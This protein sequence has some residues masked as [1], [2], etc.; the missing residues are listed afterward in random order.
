MIREGARNAAVK[1]LSFGDKFGVQHCS[2]FG[3]GEHL[4]HADVRAGLPV[5]RCRNAPAVDGVGVAAQHLAFMHDEEAGS[6]RDACRDSG[7]GAFTGALA[8]SLSTLRSS[9]FSMRSNAS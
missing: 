1:L 6:E 2:T 3:A 5:A 9:L 4:A 7:D 8:H